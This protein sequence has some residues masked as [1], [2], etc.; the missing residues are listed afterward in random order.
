MVWMT[1]SET[2]KV[3]SYLNDGSG[4]CT[5][6]IQFCKRIWFWLVYDPLLERILLRALRLTWTWLPFSLQ[7]TC[8]RISIHPAGSIFL[9]ALMTVGSWIFWSHW[10]CRLQFSIN[11]D[12]TVPLMIHRST[13]LVFPSVCSCVYRTNF[14]RWNNS[15]PADIAIVMVRVVICEKRRS[16]CRIMSAQ[17]QK[18]CMK[19][20]RVHPTSCISRLN[21]RV[22]LACH[23][24]LE[25]ILHNH[26]PTFPVK[27]LM[28]CW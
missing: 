9:S 7:T 16:L 22:D 21:A 28:Y 13:S 10:L 8:N 2:V 20:V 3:L 23:T 1:W 18:M 26:L 15:L 4:G 19:F 17:W 14:Q 12:R 6:G 11:V 24:R 27:L 25:W 5:F